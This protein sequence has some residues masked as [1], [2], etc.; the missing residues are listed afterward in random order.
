M[1][2]P[3]ARPVKVRHLMRRRLTEL[4]RTPREL[5]E[6][7]QV[8]EAY[9]ADLLAGRR[10][11]PAPSRSDVYD[12]MTRFLRLHRND[13]P[14][15]AQVERA[16]DGAATRAPS[17]VVRALLLE[18]CDPT[19]A[20]LVRR[21]LA[22]KMGTALAALIATR[23]LEIAQGFVRRQLED[24]AGIRLAANR[25][26]CAPGELRMRLFDFLDATPSSLTADDHETFLRP[27]IAAWDIDLETSTMKIVLRSS[28]PDHRARRALR[29]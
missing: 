23:L 5:A 18:L 15:C 17:P 8:P 6:A 14:M 13:L 28:E 3:L 10:R 20:R 27:R 29:L 12:R 2:A 16:D 25:E 4:K 11:P 26:G 7:V 19:R 21:R 1:A 24:D 22:G 9:I